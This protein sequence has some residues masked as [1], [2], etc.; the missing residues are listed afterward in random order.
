MD[1]PEQW[2]WKKLDDNVTT[3]AS[4]AMAREL[5]AVSHVLIKNEGDIL[6]L[7]SKLTAGKRQVAV[8]GLAD[9]SNTIVHGGG[10]GSVVPS[11]IVSP[12]ESVHKGSPPQ[13]DLQGCLTGC[14]R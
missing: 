12:L 4:V 2:D 3:A 6:P 5:S 7:P 14:L 8:F 13:L 10:S 9:S 11:F 1:V